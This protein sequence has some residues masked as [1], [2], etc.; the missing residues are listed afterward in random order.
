MAAAVK[1][2]RDCRIPVKKHRSGAR[3]VVPIVENPV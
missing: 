2:G 1:M 3:G